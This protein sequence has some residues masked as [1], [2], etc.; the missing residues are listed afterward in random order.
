MNKTKKY[1]R[2]TDKIL[3][4]HPD[5][6]NIVAECGEVIEETT[7]SVRVHILSNGKRHLNIIYTIPKDCVTP[8]LEKEVIAEM[9][10]LP[11]D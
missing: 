10:S 8:I 5:W 9:L 7:T 4:Y 11:S 3:E 2:I 1:V 6:E